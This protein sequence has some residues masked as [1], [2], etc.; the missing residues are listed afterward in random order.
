MSFHRIGIALVCD[1]KN[2]VQAIF[3]D[4]DFRRL[5]LSNQRSLPALL[6][7][8]MSKISNENFL[9]VDANTNINQA[10]EI[11]KKNSILNLPVLEG[12]KIVGLLD[13]SKLIELIV[14]KTW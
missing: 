11:M 12:D 1:E 10:I 4:G 3:T 2:E 7:T 8:E 14:D 6:V 5:I 9:Y 13:L